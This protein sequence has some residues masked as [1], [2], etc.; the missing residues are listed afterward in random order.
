MAIYLNRALHAPAGRTREQPSV[1]TEPYDKNFQLFLAASV[2]VYACIFV[3]AVFFGS[4]AVSINDVL[5]ILASRLFRFVSTESIRD[6][7]VT[8][9]GNVRL[10]RVI[11]AS[12]IGAGLSVA[13]SAAQGLLKNPLAEGSTLGISA[14]ASLGAVLFIAAG[15]HIPVLSQFGIMLNSILFALLSFVIVLSL[16]RKLDA[17]YSTHTIILTGIIFSMFVSSI[18]SLIIAF[19]SDNTMRQIIFWSMG[20][21]AGVNYEKIL[22]V[23]PFILVGIAGILAFSRELDAFSFGEEQARY[24]GVN[25]RRSK[26]LILILISMLVGVSVA[27]SGMIAFVG[28]V[29][30]HIVRLLTGPSH[31]RLLPVSIFFGAG[32]LTL[33]DLLCRTLISPLELPIGVLT[34]FVGALVFMAVFYSKRK[35]T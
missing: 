3:S 22:F 1:R 27:A 28:L 10:P 2:L 32:F 26:F 25:V 8:I 12:L 16:T 31:G 6:S 5:R 21:L 18:T 19:S 13:G 35:K 30:P 11:L 17:G 7:T 24:L 4:V 23:L 15:I 9:I 34:S 14:G 29:V 20:S 33:A